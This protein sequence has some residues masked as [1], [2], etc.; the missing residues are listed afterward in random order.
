LKS[1]LET[2]HMTPMP[3]AAEHMAIYVSQPFAANAAGWLSDA[4]SGHYEA[5]RERRSCGR[6]RAIPSE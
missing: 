2:D 5:R 1:L 3:F 4:I 6:D